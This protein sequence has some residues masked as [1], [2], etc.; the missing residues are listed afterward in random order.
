MCISFNP[1]HFP[2]PLVISSWPSGSFRNG[3]F[4]FQILIDISN[5]FMSSISNLSPLWPKHKLCAKSDPFKPNKTF[6]NQ[7]MASLGKCS[8]CVEKNTY[9]AW[10][11]GELKKC[12]SDQLVWWYFVNCPYPYW[13]SFLLSHLLEIG[14]FSLCI[15]Y[16]FSRY[17][18]C[19]SLRYTGFWKHWV[20]LMN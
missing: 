11:G 13:F 4:S 10:L 20:F 19:I 16:G 17:L 8:T 5:S 15:R 2:N 14:C 6:I 12:Q 9:S 18:F 1:T 3:L 7:N